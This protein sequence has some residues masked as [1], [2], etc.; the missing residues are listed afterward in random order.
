[1]WLLATLP[2]IVNVDVTPLSDALEATCWWDVA[3]V[4]ESAPALGVVPA[5]KTMVTVAPDARAPVAET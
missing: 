2:T 5:G 4:S 1:M 3:S